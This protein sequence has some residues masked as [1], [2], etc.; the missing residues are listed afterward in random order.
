MLN[1]ESLEHILEE[2][3]ADRG[4]YDVELVVRTLR[5]GKRVI[6]LPVPYEELRP[7]RNALVKKVL[8]NTWAL[9]IL[10]WLGYKQK[11]G[12]SDP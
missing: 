7:A 12:V 11:D 8:W 9:S 1:R 5:A 2:T 10:A 3:K 6:E 4:Q